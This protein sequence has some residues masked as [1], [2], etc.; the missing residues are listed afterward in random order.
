MKHASTLHK[1]PGQ[2]T[3]H[4]L[5]HRRLL[6][7]GRDGLPEIPALGWYCY[8]M[9]RPDVPV[10]PHPGC[11]E[12]HFRSARRAGIPGGRPIVSSSIDRRPGSYCVRAH[13]TARGGFP[14]APGVMYWLTVKVPKP[15]HGML[16]L[17]SA[18]SRLL[19]DRLLRLPDRQ[20][21][22][23]RTVKPLFDELLQLHDNSNVLLRK[24]AHGGSDYRFFCRAYLTVRIVMWFIPRS[25]AQVWPR[26]IFRRFGTTL[27]DVA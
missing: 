6:D 7:L 20:F 14:N 9:H 27:G 24:M 17:S 5:R 15:G 8:S 18:E 19:V 3:W 21:R 22:P 11:L 1:H 13:R 10:H 25:L 12:I 4:T 23:I 2:L 16:G 26:R